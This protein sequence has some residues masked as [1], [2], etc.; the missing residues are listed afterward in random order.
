MRAQLRRLHSPD[1]D[2]LSTWSPGDPS[3]AI[4]VQLFVG[5]EGATGDEAF[6]LTLC[7]PGWLAQRASGEKI[8]DL[9]HHL[10]VEKF[11]YPRLLD[12]LE[13][14]ID[15]IDGTSWPEVAVVIGRLAAWEF[16]DYVDS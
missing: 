6:T 14:R 4:L 12:Y 16:E 15:S 2:D 11:D 13:R 9:R 7:T 8:V 10:L 3:F 5:P 1:V